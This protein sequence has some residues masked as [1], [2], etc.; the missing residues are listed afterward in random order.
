MEAPAYGSYTSW[1]HCQYT[2]AFAGEERRGEAGPSP[3]YLYKAGSKMV[4]LTER[5]AAGKVKRWKGQGDVETRI[6]LNG[7][8]ALA[9]E[10]RTK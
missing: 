7:H 10:R 3:S 5:W 1:H 6:A 2:S 8:S 9:P 4:L